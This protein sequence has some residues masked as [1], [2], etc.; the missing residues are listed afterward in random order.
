[1]KEYK[2]QN[3]V[4]LFVISVIVLSSCVQ[5]EGI[6]IA[7]KKPI[8]INPD[9]T[10]DC[11]NHPLFNSFKEQN[12]DYLSIIVQFENDDQSET[13]ILEQKL[14]EELDGL[15]YKV[16]RRYEN[17]PLIAL[18]VNRE[19]FCKIIQSSIVRDI[20]LNEADSIA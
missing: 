4:L 7:I 20:S 3:V 5:Q 18:Q 1:M 15:E 17:F 11:Q 12:N 8:D 10:K 6:T 13:S 2:I 9:E 14:F 19:S 16:L